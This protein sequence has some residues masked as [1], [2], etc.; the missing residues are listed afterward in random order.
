MNIICLLFGH[1]IVTYRMGNC[2][3]CCR[4]DVLSYVSNQSESWTNIGRY[5]L[6]RWPL[7]WIWQRVRRWF[8]DDRLDD[9][10]RPMGKNK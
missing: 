9:V 5:G 8:F 4:C 7:M 1:V 10:K 6:L 3:Q 2:E